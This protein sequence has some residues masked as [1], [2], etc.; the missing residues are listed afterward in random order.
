MRNQRA[1]PANAL[2]GGVGKDEGE[3][4]FARSLRCPRPR[5]QAAGARCG[6]VSVLAS[7]ALG[8]VPARL[9]ALLGRAP[10][11]ADLRPFPVRPAA[12]PPARVAAVDGSSAVLLDGK[13]FAVG[14]YRAA[15]VALEHGRHAG[16]RAGAP[17]VALLARGPAGEA[18]EAALGAL[19]AAC[20]VAA[21]RAALATL[22]AGDLL[23]LDGALAARDATARALAEMLDE[24]AARGAHVA[25]VAK[26]TS[27]SIGGVPVLALAHRAGVA[28][29]L[30]TWAVEVPAAPGVRGRSF[31]A[32]LSAAEPWVFRVDVAPAP[33][34]APADALALAATLVGHPAYPGYPSPLAMAHNAATIDE[35]L[36]REL[37]RAVRRAAEDAGADPTLLALAF[38]DYHDVLDLAR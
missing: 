12:A 23:L 10:P 28:S 26:S 11:V 7:P 37:A 20:E 31:A 29:G 9:A 1:M 19:R 13:S 34:A 3:G 21:A 17:D 36:A 27:Q 33:G 32:R 16:T 2:A 30:A 35:P 38:E 25:G 22:G 18:P 8:D 24:A 4:A 15:V 6:R 14:A 5:L